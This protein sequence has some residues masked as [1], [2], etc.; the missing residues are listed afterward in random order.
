MKRRKWGDGGLKPDVF[1]DHLVKE[2]F[3][4]GLA[5]TMALFLSSFFPGLLC[6]LLETAGLGPGTSPRLCQG[7]M[8]DPF[9]MAVHSLRLALTLGGSHILPF[10]C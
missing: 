4:K 1:C 10:P 9:W 2:H 5:V 8:P 3:H 7:S 6:L